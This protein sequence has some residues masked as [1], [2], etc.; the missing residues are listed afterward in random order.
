MP[1]AVLPHTTDHGFILFHLVQ[2]IVFLFDILKIRHAVL[3]AHD[4]EQIKLVAGLLEF[5]G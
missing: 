2:F 1:L 4:I 3:V 5:G